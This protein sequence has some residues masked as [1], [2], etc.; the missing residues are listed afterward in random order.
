MNAI[1]CCNGVK[2]GEWSGRCPGGADVPT[3]FL[4]VLQGCVQTGRSTKHTLTFTQ[5]ISTHLQCYR[6]GHS[7]F[8]I[9]IQD[10]GM[11]KNNNRLI[12]CTLIKWQLHQVYNYVT[13]LV[14]RVLTLCTLKL[15]ILH[16]L[17]LWGSFARSQNKSL[18]MLEW[19]QLLPYSEKDLVSTPDVGPKA[20]LWKCLHM[21]AWVFSG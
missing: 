17:W 12:Q 9:Q 2:N 8:Q 18:M 5:T 14:Q 11:E 4:V 16:F 19:G 3:P 21:S 6:C 7:F 13:L 10:A 15:L 1:S 20:F